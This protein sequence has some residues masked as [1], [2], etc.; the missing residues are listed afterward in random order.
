MSDS[1]DPMDYSSQGMVL[2]KKRELRFKASEFCL[3]IC[4]KISLNLAFLSYKMRDSDKVLAKSK[5]L[6]LD[7]QYACCCC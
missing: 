1:C 4:N 7:L 5:Y 6:N 3:N 2:K